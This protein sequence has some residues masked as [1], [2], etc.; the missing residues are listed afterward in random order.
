VSDEQSGTPLE[1]QE[2][3]AERAP[4]FLVRGGASDEE[5]AALTAVLSA[6]GSGGGAPA[7]R[8]A[9]A[10]ADPARS[11]RRPHHSGRGGWRASGLPR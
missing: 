9:R 4:L 1:G 7:R 3:P 10:W 6:L 5:V 2:Q 11:H 8:P